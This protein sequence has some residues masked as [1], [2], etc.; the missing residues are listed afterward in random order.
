MR[1]LLV[2]L[3]VFLPPSV[4]FGQD[5]KSI[6]IG[7]RD[8][9]Y[10]KILKEQRDLLVYL[11]AGYDARK[12]YPVAY[13]LDGEVHFHFFTGI[14]Q[15][16]SGSYVIPE[17]IVIGIAN[18]A[19]T[20]DLTP[21]HDALH[22][23]KANGGGEA[24]TAFI[25]QE[26]VPFVNSRYA[27]APYRL[28][29][30]HSLG[31]LLVVNTLLHHPSLFHSFVAIDPSLWWDGMK[32]VH[33]SAVAWEKAGTK[34]SLFLA[35][36]NSMPAGMTDTAQAKRDTTPATI[37]IRSVFLMEDRLKKAAPKDLRW[38]SQYYPT[39]FHGSVPLVA[40][41]DG[42]KF[43]FDFYRRPSFQRLTDSTIA[44]LGDHY[45][46][47]SEKMGYA[48]LPPESDLAG[49]AWRSAVL[50][51]EYTR[52]WTFLQ[53]YQKL[54][55]DSPAMYDSFGQYY[56]TRGEAEKA[57]CFYK[58]AEALREKAKTKAS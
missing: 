14:V 50:E 33:P 55:P 4:L 48:I 10:S 20:R 39:E 21:T 34:K 40:A 54:Y 3:L 8:S 27:A 15:H 30:G 45:K 51:K 37:G 56:E 31:G 28:L 22:F 44:I 19:R 16:L 42:L 6:S 9:L 13:L 58:K 53:L 24:F 18:T 26:L 2:I 5:T 57:K 41:Y 32:L 7:H 29:V 23:D 12:R 49:L 47:V 25:A 35:I 36:A 11:P 17:M 52:A 1:K 43:L 46:R 38:R